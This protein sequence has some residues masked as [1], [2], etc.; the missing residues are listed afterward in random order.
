MMEKIS[1]LLNGSP[2][3]LAPEE[4]AALTGLPVPPLTDPITQVMLA[5]TELAD[6]QEEISLQTGLALAE[7]AE[8]MLN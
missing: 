5:L 8:A 4:L 6:R 1:V 3:V 2:Q 7:L